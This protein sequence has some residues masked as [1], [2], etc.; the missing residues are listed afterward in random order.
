M[1][2]NE[3]LTAFVKTGLS[4]NLPRTDIEGVLLEAGWP[5]DQV[6]AA[7]GS[8][9]EIEFPVPVPR[10]NPSISAR[11]AF[12]YLVMFV[13]LYISAFSLGSLLF[14]FINMAFPD[15]ALAARPVTMVDDAIRWSV[16]LLVVTFPVFVFVARLIQQ[17]VARDPSRRASRVR[18]WLTYLTAFVAAGFLMGDVATLVYNVLGGELT[19]RFLLK[20]FTVASIAGVV[21]GYYLKDLK[22]DES[23]EA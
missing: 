7:L 10:P 21:F 13:S 23:E 1:N 11:E 2:I 14:Q 18:R 20:A 16:S 5:G 6:R 9:A 3:D 22:R 8:F 19:V 17:D 15:P 12:L 4:R